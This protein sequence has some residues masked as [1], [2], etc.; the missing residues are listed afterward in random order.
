MNPLF[1]FPFRRR[2]RRVLVVLRR[3]HRVAFSRDWLHEIIDTHFVGWCWT[4]P[5]RFVL[6][7]F[8]VRS[9]KEEG[10]H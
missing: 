5:N 4:A 3:S 9:V 2:R 7:K 6:S 8:E 10:S 1:F